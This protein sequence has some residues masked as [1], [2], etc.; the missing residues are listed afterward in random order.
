MSASRLFTIFDRTMAVFLVSL[1]VIV[2]GA[3]AVV[4]G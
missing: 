4:G 1:G 3:T 2:A